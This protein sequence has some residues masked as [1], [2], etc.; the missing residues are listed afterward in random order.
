MESA[1]RDPAVERIAV[2]PERGV[3]DAEQP[4]GLRHQRVRA[5]QLLQRA[6][7]QVVLTLR[8]RLPRGHQECRQVATRLGLLP[9]MCR[10]V[11]HHDSGVGEPVH[12]ARHLELGAAEHLGQRVQVAGAVHRGEHLPLERDQVQG[13]G[14]L[15][16]GQP[17]HQP[18]VR[19]L[20]PDARPLIDPPRRLHQQRLGREPHR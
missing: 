2:P 6:G 20:R 8:Q 5:Q 17:R 11:Q 9:R 19:H 13:L 3:A 14:P 15:L 1:P 10:I 16:L 4:T 18:Q 7:G 12:R